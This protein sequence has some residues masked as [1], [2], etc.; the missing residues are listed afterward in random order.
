[1]IY[2]L[3]G[4]RR[5]RHLSVA[6]VSEEPTDNGKREKSTL[7][8]CPNS[9]MGD[10]FRVDVTHTPAIRGYTLRSYPRLL[11]GDAF[12]VILLSSTA[13]GRMIMTTDYTDY[14]DYANYTND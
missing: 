13:T 12:S 1:M 6:V 9:A 10:S 7:K 3:C 14:T 11:N 4:R 2:V 8:A 5:K